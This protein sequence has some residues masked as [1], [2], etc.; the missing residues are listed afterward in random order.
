[1]SLAI[2]FAKKLFG[3]LLYNKLTVDKTKEY[4]EL[5]QRIPQYKEQL[6]QIEHELYGG[7]SYVEFKIDCNELDTEKNL[8]PERFSKIKQLI[9]CDINDTISYDTCRLQN[10]HRNISEKIE[11]ASMSYKQYQQYAINRLRRD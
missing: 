10:E 4:W 6:L 8:N 11:L 3:S 9:T 7:I 2:Q 1:M 5:K